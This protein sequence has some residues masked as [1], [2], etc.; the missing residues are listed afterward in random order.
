MGLA[1]H[2]PLRK[3]S[4]AGQGCQVSGRRG[5]TRKNGGGLLQSQP[6]RAGS[7]RHSP[8]DLGCYKTTKTK[9]APREASSPHGR[10]RGASFG[11]VLI[12]LVWQEL[13]FPAQQL[14]RP[15]P[16]EDPCVVPFILLVAAG[17]LSKA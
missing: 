12:F 15:S 16:E 4:H 2:R 3:P 13:A 7:F 9:A 14:C 11:N 6:E 17:S 10:L 1:P 5:V 8:C